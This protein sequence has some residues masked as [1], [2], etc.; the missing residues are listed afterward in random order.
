MSNENENENSLSCLLEVIPPHLCRPEQ[1]AHWER[2]GEAFT[3]R[4]LRNPISLEELN[5]H[6]FCMAIW[7]DNGTLTYVTPHCDRDRHDGPSRSFLTLKLREDGPFLRITGS[8]DD[9]VAQTV[10]FFLSFEQPTEEN[11]SVFIGYLNVGFDFREAGTHWIQRMFELRPSTSVHFKGLRFSLQQS[12]VLAS[13]SHQTGLLLIDCELE[14][15]GNAFLDELVQRKSTFGSLTFNGSIPLNEN[16]FRRLLQI[17]TVGHLGLPINDLNDELVLLPFSTRAAS[18]D[19]TMSSSKL[20][21][22]DLSAL[23]I[24]PKKLIIT[25]E[26]EGGPIRYEPL[27]SLLH[28]I[29]ELG[30][31]EELGVRL[32]YFNDFLQDN[33]VHAVIA[34]ALSNRNLK[35]LD[36]SSDYGDDAWCPH[37][38]T[39][40]E[41]LKD[42][43]NLDTL[44]FSVDT[45]AFGPDFCDLLQFISHN[46]NIIVTDADGA[47]YSDGA[48]VDA[49]YSLNRFYVGSK[50]LLTKLDL[51][52]ERP[53]LVA[54]ALVH[55]A[56]NDFQRNALLLSD[57][58]DVLYDFIRFA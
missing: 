28:R 15:G 33:V 34:A 40:F 7:R 6:K 25:I 32:C 41:A 47:L 10:A 16:N 49:Q 18:L 14:D 38:G 54:T 13:R 4:L 30:H 27:L 3:Y 37:L 42:K 20:L 5:Q 26:H 22:A 48:L 29:A 45:S 8:T 17:D 2:A 12:S 39:L 35:V 36:L 52:L 11:P 53:L 21:G 24:A 56:L 57:Y 51:Q 46:R 9:A 43:E 1:V 31:F 58:A 44:Q 55:S 23:I 19:S 50:T